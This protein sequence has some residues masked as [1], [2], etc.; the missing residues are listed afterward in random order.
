MNTFLA[1]PALLA[2]AIASAPVAQ[3]Y[4]GDQADAEQ[5]VTAI[6][7]QV[8]RGCTPSMPPS[9]R[10]IS[11]TRFNPDSGGEGRIVDANQAWAARSPQRTGTRKLAPPKTPRRTA[12]TGSGVSTLSSVEQ[13]L[14]QASL[15]KP[16][17]APEANIG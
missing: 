2:V 5:A 4:P 7:N 3:A 10:S 6:Y 14:D 1:V 12:G 9:L 8:Q 11:W 15:T 13:Q 17:S 16:S